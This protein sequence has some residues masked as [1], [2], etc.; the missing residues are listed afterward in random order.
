M[1]TMTIVAFTIPVTAGR[2]LA[3]FRGSGAAPAGGTAAPAV[4]KATT[5]QPSEMGLGREPIYPYRVATRSAFGCEEP[6]S[7]GRGWHLAV[8][9]NGGLL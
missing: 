6:C 1:P 7:D 5:N 8:F 4:S 3:L 9:N 2:R